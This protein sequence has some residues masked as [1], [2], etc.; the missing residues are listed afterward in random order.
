MALS[1]SFWDLAERF[2]GRIHADTGFP[3]IVCDR[4]G[5]IRKAYVKSRIGDLHAGSKQILT[6]TRNDYEVTAAEAAANPLVKEG[7]N[8]AIIVDGSK[9]A[10][11]GLAGPL[12]ITRPVAKTA[13][14]L[15]ASWIKQLREQELLDETANTVAANLQTLTAK[16]E[17]AAAQYDQ[18]WNSMSAAAKKATASANSADEVIRGLEKI[19]EQ[20][21]I[22]SI[23]GNIEASRLGEQGR[24]FGAIAQQMG[25]LSQNTS[26]ALRAVQNTITEM[27]EVLASVSAAVEQS[28]TMFRDNAEMMKGVKSTMNEV[29]SS[30]A[31]L[32]LA[33]KD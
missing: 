18:V 27:R 30:I 22:L 9:V 16:V 6:G 3:A 20:S 29:V 14:L 33:M 5:I 19:A 31:K 4:E 26:Q 23:N 12:E 8:C 21:Q 2:V 32:K 28:S 10:T 13:S 24:V 7:Y 15:M 17:G 25:H 1:A 11:F